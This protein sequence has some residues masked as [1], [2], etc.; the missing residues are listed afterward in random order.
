MISQEFRD[1]HALYAEALLGTTKNC[2]NAQLIVMAQSIT[3]Y[4]VVNET[5]RPEYQDAE[6]G[7]GRRHALH[8]FI[9]AAFYPYFFAA[10]RRQL[11]T[12]DKLCT[13]R[14][15]VYSLNPVIL[16][17]LKHRHVFT[18][19]NLLYRAEKLPVAQPEERQCPIPIDNRNHTDLH[20]TR[21][22]YQYLDKM[23]DERSPTGNAMDDRISEARLQELAD[24][25]AELEKF[26]CYVDKFIAHAASADSVAAVDPDSLKINYVD[27]LDAFQT[28]C[29]VRQV[30]CSLL[31][32]LSC[33]I[34]PIM[35]FDTLENIDKPIIQPQHMPSMRALMN[36]FQK[37]AEATTQQ[38]ASDP[39]WP[40]KA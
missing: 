11:D 31:F 18:R 16:H 24:R 34:V 23:L 9:D 7:S 36:G 8:G 39:W 21:L 40:W 37:K 1:C 28:L 32:Q 12:T 38:N 10:V 22:R 33:G 29:R 30:L 20:L 27:V 26:K 15:G 17:M 3:F 14:K 25:L 19:E 4:Q 13:G 6:A 2:V 5:R 35:T